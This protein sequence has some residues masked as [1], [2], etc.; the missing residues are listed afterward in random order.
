[1]IKIFLK[2]FYSK[3]D[4]ILLGFKHYDSL[5]QGAQFNFKMWDTAGYMTKSLE[6]QKIKNKKKFLIINPACLKYSIELRDR[7]E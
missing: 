2:E 6:Q 1:M 4:N 5:Y 7:K 3:K